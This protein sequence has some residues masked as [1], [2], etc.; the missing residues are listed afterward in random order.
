MNRDIIEK[1]RTQGKW[2]E[3]YALFGGVGAIIYPIMFWWLGWMIIDERDDHLTCIHYETK[4]NES[5]GESSDD[6]L[7][8]AMFFNAVMIVV[9]LAMH[10]TLFSRP[11]EYNTFKSLGIAFAVVLSLEVIFAAILLIL[12]GI[13]ICNG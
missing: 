5:K 3:S 7:R 9:Y 2:A 11:E 12:S 1:G 10:F 8:Q 4:I 13:S 6:Y